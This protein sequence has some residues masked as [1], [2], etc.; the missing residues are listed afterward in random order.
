[1]AHWPQPIT[2]TRAFPPGSMLKQRSGNS[3]RA[4][5]ELAPRVSFSWR[6]S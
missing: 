5:A 3:F 2:R 6:E 1:M 4:F